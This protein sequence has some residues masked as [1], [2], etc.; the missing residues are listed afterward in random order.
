M[1]RAPYTAKGIKR[2]PCARCGEPSYAQWQICS[3]GNQRR[4][5]CRKCDV[6][7]NRVTMRY[8]FGRSRD[9]DIDAYAKRIL[10]PS[11]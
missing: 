9:A 11:P 10:T 3:D 2:V 5:L 4:G 7:L 1:R 6:G 8:V